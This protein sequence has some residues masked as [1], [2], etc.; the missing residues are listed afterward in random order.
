[1]QVPYGQ[2]INKKIVVKYCF[3]ITLLLTSLNALSQQP[4]DLD[5][6]DHMLKKEYHREVIHLVNRSE[7]NNL[8][9]SGKD[10][11]HYMKGWSHY[12]LK[13]LEP[14]ANEL[15]QVSQNSPF[16]HK[17]RFFAAYNQIHLGRYPLAQASLDD[18]QTEK[19]ELQS[20]RHFEKAG[21]A[22]LKRDFDRFDR[23]FSR[24]DTSYYPLA[25]E[26]AQIS[27]YATTLENHQAKSPVWGGI[28][29]SII[30]GS[31]KI[32]AGQTGEGISS[33][34]T[35]GG[36]GLVT[37]ENYRKRGIKDWR[38]LIF[39]AAFSAFY[40]GNIYGTVFSIQIAEDEFQQEY[41][42]KILFNLHIPLR[43]V[44]Q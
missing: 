37:W 38:T 36:L 11:M 20:L 40:V 23:E 44:F 7:W 19:A 41:D 5:F 34:L 43:N 13:Q 14:S 21:I 24:V 39:G 4:A 28:M 12:A 6:V 25:K 18:I 17:A 22:L 3:A 27:K 1:M 9:P 15:N 10:S 33:L 42:H 30:P 16:Y 35:V 29:S 26:S 32:Y 8:A 31:G 2:C